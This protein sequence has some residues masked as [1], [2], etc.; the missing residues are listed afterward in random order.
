MR[1]R[2]YYRPHPNRAR[3]LPHGGVIYPSMVHTIELPWE[4]YREALQYEFLL[5]EDIY[6]IQ[7]GDTLHIVCGIY[8]G[9]F[10]T[11][12]RS[13]FAHAKN[14]LVQEG[15]EA[16]YVLLLLG[17]IGPHKPKPWYSKHSLDVLFSKE[18]THGNA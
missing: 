7:H 18:E 9:S 11:G 8:P 5:I 15:I 10:D 2:N 1:P 13:F 16:G 14:I 17:A 6:G 3:A 12:G 4:R